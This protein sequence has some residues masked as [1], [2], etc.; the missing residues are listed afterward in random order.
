MGRAEAA[1]Q[2]I[3]PEQQGLGGSPGSHL[4]TP[5][6]PRQSPSLLLLGPS[7][8]LP[9]PRPHA[10]LRKEPWAL[11]ALGHPVSAP[12]R[13]AGQGHL[14]GTAGTS[15][16]PELADGASPTRQALRPGPAPLPWV[17]SEEDWQLL[18]LGLDVLSAE[19]ALG[20]LLALPQ[21]GP[22]SL[23]PCVQDGSIW[24]QR[25]GLCYVPLP[26]AD[27]SSL[28]RA[29][30]KIRGALGPGIQPEPHPGQEN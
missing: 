26:A 29:G 3:P 27:R 4:S 10:S 12:S 22:S 30:L 1:G 24:R 16:Y 6:G 2:A 17:C 11:L 8:F 7:N 21:W 9:T 14:S 25:M 15:V 13:E 18:A 23:C 19:T 20:L 5:H 28:A